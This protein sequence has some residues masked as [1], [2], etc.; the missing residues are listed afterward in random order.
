MLIWHEWTPLA[1]ISTPSVSFTQL[2]NPW[3]GKALE[4]SSRTVVPQWMA[5]WEPAGSV[6]NTVA[7]HHSEDSD[8]VDPRRHPETCTFIKFPGRCDTA[9]PYTNQAF[10][11][12]SQGTTPKASHEIVYFFLKIS[13]EFLQLPLLEMLFLSSSHMSQPQLSASSWFMYSFIC[14]FIQTFIL[15]LWCAWH[16]ANLFH[17]IPFQKLFSQHEAHDLKHLI[18]SFLTWISRE[19]RRRDFLLHCLL[20]SFQGLSLM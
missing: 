11:L 10:P 2:W 7:R 1:W 4:M 19:V 15:H 14:P 9:C 6:L 13:M 5:T 16:S 8:S 17:C 20:F 18:S 12:S 3:V